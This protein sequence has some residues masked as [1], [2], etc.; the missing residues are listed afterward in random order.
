MAPTFEQHLDQRISAVKSKLDE[1][2]KQ[3]DQIYCLVYQGALSILLQLQK[4]YEQ[5]KDRDQNGSKK[6][7]SWWN[8]KG[9]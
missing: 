5:L 3:D 2:V 6:R 9:T 1:A 8:F 4:D 7:R